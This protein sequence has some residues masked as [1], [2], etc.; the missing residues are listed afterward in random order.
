MCLLL[1]AKELAAKALARVLLF[2]N[3]YALDCELHPDCE[4]KLDV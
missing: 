4:S 2:G 3:S 1:R